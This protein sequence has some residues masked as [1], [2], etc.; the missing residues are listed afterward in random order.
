LEETIPEIDE[1]I[2]NYPKKP[3]FGVDIQ[4]H[5]RVSI[6]INPNGISPVIRKLIES[7]IEQ[8]A[9]EEEGIFRIGGS[10]AKMNRLISAIN[11]GY[12]DYIDFKEY[13]V[14]CLA[15][16]LKQYLRDLPDSIM[17]NDLYNDWINA[18]KYISLSPLSLSLSL[19]YYL[20]F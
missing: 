18:T 14:H 10:K 5:L 4:E 13:D 9:F 11:S 16:V 19:S 20:S 17:C 3:I 2:N 15:S 6:S 7:M 8:N 1:T 12:L